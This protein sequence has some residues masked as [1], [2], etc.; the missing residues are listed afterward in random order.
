MDIYTI[1]KTKDTRLTCG[2]KWLVWNDFCGT[3]QV[4]THKWHARQSDLLI[5]TAKLEDA[6]DMLIRE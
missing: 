6:L 4:Y 5:D 1:L 3:W 2:D